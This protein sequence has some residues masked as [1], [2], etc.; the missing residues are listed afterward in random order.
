[1]TKWKRLFNAFVETQNRYQVGNHLIMFINRAMNPVSYARKR[2]AF[3]WWRDE[4]NVVLAFSGFYIRED[5]KV[6]LSS[7]ESTLTGARQRADSS[8]VTLLFSLAAG[9]RLILWV[10]L[11]VLFLTASSTFCFFIPYSSPRLR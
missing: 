5:G 11:L 6:V 8:L 7:T 2:D 9:S 4:L 3:E 1:M 10:T